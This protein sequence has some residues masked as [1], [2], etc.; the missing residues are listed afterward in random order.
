M[1]LKLRVIYLELIDYIIVHLINDINTQLNN[2]R[3]LKKISL[4]RLN[5]SVLK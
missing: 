4:K 5:K 1:S 2:L 3:V